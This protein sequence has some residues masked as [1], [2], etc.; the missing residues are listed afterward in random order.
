MTWLAVA[1]GLWS[2]L[3]G[4]VAA[5]MLAK[6]EFLDPEGDRIDRLLRVICAL[7]AIAAAF[8]SGLLL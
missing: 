4:A 2:L 7:C 6:R 3:F 5:D 8:A 1:L